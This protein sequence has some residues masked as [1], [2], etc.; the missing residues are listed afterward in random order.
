MRTPNKFTVLYNSIT[1]R[2]PMLPRLIALGLGLGLVAMALIAQKR[3]AATAQESSQTAAPVTRAQSI[4]LIEIASDPN[5]PNGITHYQPSNSLLLS[6]DAGLQLLGS[7][8]AR[9]ALSSFGAQKAHTNGFIAAR[10]GGN[11]FA[12]GDVFAG[13]DTPGVILRVSTAAGSG[14]ASLSSAQNLKGVWAVLDGESGV[15]SGLSFESHDPSAGSARG[16][17]N[18]DLIA[19][20]SGGGVWRIDSTGA[21]RRVTALITS[22][23]SDGVDTPVS[24]TAVSVAP[25][26][27]AKYGE[28]AGRILA[29]AGQQGTIYAIDGEGQV[30]TF[31]SGLKDVN[32]LLLIP[33]KENFFGLA[34][35]RAASD[36]Q[37]QTQGTIWGAP[38]ADFAAVVGDFL[39]TQAG[40]DAC[41]CRPTLWSVRWNGSGFEKTKLSELSSATPG[42]EWGQ[43]TFSP[44]GGDLFNEIGQ[45]NLAPGLTLVKAVTD[46]NGGFIQ[47]GD[48]LEYTLTL[49]NPSSVPVGKSFIAEFIPANTDYVPGS[50]RITAGANAGAKTDGADDDQLDAF[51]IGGRVV[52]FNIGIG[53]GAG[54]H[55]V[56]G[57]LR[58]GTL[59]P[60]ESSTVAFRV[61]VKAGLAEGAPIINGAQWGAEDIYPGGNSNVVSNTVGSPL[62]LEKSVTDVNGGQVTPGDIL[63][64]KLVLTNQSFNL[65]TK[66]FIA[67]F[68]PKG[69]TYV[70]N[71]VQ[72][73][74]GANMGAKTDAGDSDQ[75]TYFPTA[76]VN[77]QINI[78]TGLGAGGVSGGL[79]GGALAS[80]E[81]TTVVFRVQV[82]SGQGAESV[83]V[84][85]A[86][87][88]A[89]DMYPI[90]SSNVV[91]TAVGGVATPL[92]GP[93]GQAGATGPTDNND[94]FTLA[95]VN[96]T[97][98]NGSTIETGSVRFINTV[99]NVG[100]N[101]GKFVISAPT[102]PQGFSVKVSVDSGATFVSLS[103]GGTATTPTTVNVNEERNIDVR[104]DL[105]VGL[106]INTNYDVVI[107][108]A[109]EVDSTK[110]NRTIDRVR[111]DPNPPNLTLV[112]S[113]RDLTGKDIAGG[114]VSRGQTI[115][116]RLTLTNPT[117]ASIGN[118]FIAEFLPL[119]VAYVAGSTQI[120]S[121]PN[122]GAKTDARGDDQVDFFP[123]GFVNGQINIFTGTGA[124]ALKGGT[125]AAGESTT[126]VFRAKVLETAATGTAIPNGA[127]WGAEDFAIGGKSNIVTVT[128]TCPTITL[129]P[130]AGAL[131]AGVTGTDYNQS[132]TQTGGVAP[133]S[134]L[135]SAGGLPPGLSLN[136]GTGAL[137][138]KPT[139]A[140]NY[141]FTV[142]A[143]DAGG[144]TG[145]AAY[146][147]AVGGSCVAPA[148]TT[149]PT[150]R[151]VCAGNETT[152]LVTATG[153]NLSYQWRK[154]GVNI[155]EA[156]T[157]GLTLL[158]VKATDAGNYD[159]VISNSCGTVTSTAAA[160]IVN[161]KPVI[162]SQP[163]SLTKG[164]GQSATFSV[165]ATGPS[166][167]YQ[168]RKD[169]VNISGATASSFTIP[170]VKTGDAGSYDVV[171]TDTCGS[172]TSTA[173]TLT[174]TCQS[175][176]VG[177]AALP[178]GVVGTAYNQ[179]FTQ[180]GGV[181]P[182]T[183]SVSEGA[184]ATGLALN[185]T[186]GALT[187]IPTEA[188]QFSFTVKATD[189]N[190]CAGVQPYLLTVT[191]SAGPDCRQTICFRS[192][193]YFSLN[194][195]T[196]AIPNG[197]VLIAGVNLNNPISTTDARVKQAL[198]EVYGTF[199]REYVAVQL[200][201]L[202][203]SGLGA[204]NVAT[205]LASQLSCYGLQFN[206]VTL[207]TGPTLST[208][209][210]L[211]DLIFNA[212]NVVKGI[213]SDGDI[214]I[215]T[216]LFIALNGFST[217]NVCNRP[218]GVLDLTSACPFN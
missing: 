109:S 62:K 205:A 214:C 147:L 25:N 38:A 78:A 213:G 189:A 182:V 149:Q 33:A 212:N 146:T 138:G 74:A 204:A 104:V 1:R 86:N 40:S 119:N 17:F 200:N 79:A 60:G 195:G 108:A 185:P 207:T 91:S 99:K 100:T 112:K 129:T 177:P 66:S 70:P 216:R 181:T 126:V 120:A 24:F 3:Y 46:L 144:C 170:S 107:Q 98:S 12:A 2:S 45:T 41:Q 157:S 193:A 87:A 47:P 58:G 53:V 11:G 196:T 176:T 68:I 39:V 36:K 158:N 152:F 135:V 121:G 7:A 6:S 42:V 206:T 130:A 103:Q 94:D 34:V 82:N 95:R 19:V 171:V 210:P 54:G 88:G 188:G 9:T 198:N 75:V 142:T 113:V 76:G 186:T 161:D 27:S 145:S 56:G 110:V 150:P 143:T 21:A 65:V 132:I 26:D 10:E 28:L 4:H 93:F 137:T 141:S 92:I 211:S 218:T 30:K 14:A 162:T 32:N 191:Q 167:T 35:E 202:A 166:L 80:G 85:A 55:P 117:N 122:A 59:A 16:A 174:I 96:L 187:G 5:G 48:T 57:L 184:L 8:G 159:V 133:V 217:A 101:P 199:N 209:S 115:E 127:N 49:S 155:P 89:N 124:T 190:G 118:T 23:S 183:F 173:A 102:I 83:I 114:P 67:E 172:V 163:V 156:T 131:P 192:A 160:L 123:S 203:A 139:T 15:V 197:S 116:Y 215:I 179:S 165:T 18:G 154:N 51:A 13:G 148:I 125:L 134:F 168:W 169:G 72:I 52:Q 43:V 128:V 50:V 90:A 140:G 208:S 73:T 105:P 71:S 164:A 84:N 61:L 69:V 44:S 37:Q 175:I 22:R 31:D 151:T 194:F 111:P 97:V 106:A 178:V 153:T 63:E 81:S 136:L 180:T 29:V 201:V 20:T 64:Y 77:G